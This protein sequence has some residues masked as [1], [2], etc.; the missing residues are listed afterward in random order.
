MIE[1]IPKGHRVSLKGLP[2]G[3]FEH[4][5]KIKVVIDDR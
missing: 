4:K 1:D 3:Q 2:L 5:K